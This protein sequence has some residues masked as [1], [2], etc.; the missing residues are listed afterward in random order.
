MLAQG[1]PFV[2]RVALG[3]APARVVSGEQG[4]TRLAFAAF[5]VRL[6]LISVSDGDR[7]NHS[8]GC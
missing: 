1:K 8:E 5:A 4:R 7:F 3:A 6:G 2:Y